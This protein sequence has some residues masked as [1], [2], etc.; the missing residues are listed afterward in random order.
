MAREGNTT[1]WMYRCLGRR[2]EMLSGIQPRIFMAKDVFYKKQK[3]IWSS[4]DL[5]MRKI[6]VKCTT[7]SVKHGLWEGDAYTF[8]N[9][10]EDEGKLNRAWYWRIRNIKDCS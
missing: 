8:V 5:K 7:W 4:V 1:S 9:N 6:F 10:A 3:L 2:L